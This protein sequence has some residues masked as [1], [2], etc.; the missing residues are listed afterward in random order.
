MNQNYGINIIERKNA[1]MYKN[2]QQQR[3]M[4]QAQPHYMNCPQLA[5]PSEGMDMSDQT[6]QMPMNM[7]PMN[8]TPT[9]TTPTNMTPTTLESPYYIAG[10]LRTFIGE[11][12]RVQ[13][14]IGTNGPLVDI[15]GTL[16]EVGANYIILQPIETDDLTVCDLYAIKFVTVFR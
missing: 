4:P 13:F 14:L 2:Y 5:A 11:R 3:Q 10:L 8:T 1:Q 15:N 12:M 7:M 6:P 16:V 9:N